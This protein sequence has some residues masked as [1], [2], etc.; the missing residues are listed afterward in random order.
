MC[1]ARLGKWSVPQ[2]QVIH[3]GTATLIKSEGV[4]VWENEP[5]ALPYAEYVSW[6]AV[7][8][9]GKEL[10]KGTGGMR[11]LFD[12]FLERIVVKLFQF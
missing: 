7:A 2:L 8:G 3:L 4:R 6:S 11:G 10:N 1:R 9:A 12:P 5:N